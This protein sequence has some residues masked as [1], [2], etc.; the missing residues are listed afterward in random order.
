MLLIIIGC[1]LAGNYITQLLTGGKYFNRFCWCLL[2]C[3]YLFLLQPAH[4]STTGFFSIK[5]RRASWLS[6]I[7]SSK[8]G[9]SF[10]RPARFGENDRGVV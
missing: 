4:I 2:T 1:R 7:D 6:N 9:I 3:G 8:Q 5:E 10:D